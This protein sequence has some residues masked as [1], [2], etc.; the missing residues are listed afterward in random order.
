MKPQRTTDITLG[1]D[2][3]TSSVKV[4]ALDAQGQTLGVGKADYQVSLPHQGWSECNPDAWWSGVVAAVKTVLLQIPSTRIYSIGLSGQ[5]HGVVLVDT[6]YQPVRPAMLWSDTRAETELEE[7]RRLPTSMRQRLA[8]PLVAGMAGP[9]LSWL[10][11]HEPA[12]YQA[13][14]WAIQ[15]K[16]WIRLRLT[17]LVAAEQSDASATLLYDLPADHWADDVVAILGLRSEI[18]PDILLSTVLAGT[19]CVS[20]ARELG[21]PVGLPIAAGAADTA[22]AALGTGLFTPDII[23][24]TVGTGAQLIKICEQPI[25]DPT[26]RTHL[27]RAAD[28]AHWY[29]MA[30]VQNAGLALDWV[31]RMLNASW[32]ELY[33]SV[34]RV[35]P[36]A[37]GLLF[38]PYVT[39]ERPHHRDRGSQGAWSHLRIDHRREHLLH[40]ALEGVAFGIREALDAL[41]GAQLSTSLRLA[42]GG[43]QHPAWQQMLATILH[44]ELIVV[45]TP[46]AS[47]RGAALLGGLA[48][49]IWPDMAAIAAISPELATTIPFDADQAVT[50]DALYAQYLRE[51]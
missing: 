38:L 21:L 23:Q 39:R 13:T 29:S 49:G 20:A 1:I 15:P 31:C 10:A 7:Y 42:G 30:A 50:Y 26:L 41:P 25:P 24:L 32:D 12:S 6:E 22:A 14:R 19:L 11:R 34:T 46:D 27:Y 44:R 45:D 28:G 5:M 18:L 33:G 16:D 8:N 4:L 17:G 51:A 9:M 3:G 35:S 47:A 48:S 40:A 43:G 36:G 37:E 2:L